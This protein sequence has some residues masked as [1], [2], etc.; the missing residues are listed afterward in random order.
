MRESA[1]MVYILIELSARVAR[2]RE[3]NTSPIAF[4]SLPRSY[5]TRSQ[6]TTYL[7]P[8]NSFSR[9]N[10][11]NHDSGK[12]VKKFADVLATCVKSGHVSGISASHWSSI[13]LGARAFPRRPLSE[14]Y[15]RHSTLLWQKSNYFTSE[16][17]QQ[18]SWV[19]CS[20]N[21]AS[22]EFKHCW[23]IFTF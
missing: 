12:L 7:F 11:A 23:T 3:I 21:N 22:N 5:R 18:F 16:G 19:K 2:G 14:I 4:Y 15:C 9:A 13:Y 1:E 8:C 6:Q 10:P 20:I 17:I